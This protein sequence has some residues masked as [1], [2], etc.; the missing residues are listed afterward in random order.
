MATET[1]DMGIAAPTFSDVASGLEPGVYSAEN[2]NPPRIGDGSRTSH[3][4]VH[5]DGNLSWCSEDG[6]D[7]GY[8]VFS[9]EELTEPE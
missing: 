1:S 4:R 3:L 9:A 6:V 2:L 5:A 7:D 8:S